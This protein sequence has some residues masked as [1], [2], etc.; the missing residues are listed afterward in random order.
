MYRTIARRTIWS[1][2]MDQFQ[3]P[4]AVDLTLVAHA[5]AVET[6]QIDLVARGWVG[7]F[8]ALL[9]PG[10]NGSPLVWRE[11]GPGGEAE[12]KR[13]Y[14]A[15]FGRFF[16]R[17][18]LRHEHGCRDLRQVHDGREIASGLRIRRRRGVSARGDLPDWV[19][20]NATS[21][22]Y[23]VC[24]AKGSHDQG[25]W[26]VRVPP[27]VNAAMR[28]TNRMEIIDASGVRVQTKNWVVASRWGTQGNARTPTVI[29]MDPLSDGRPLTDAEREKLPRETHA[30][31]LADLLKGLGRAD[32]VGEGGDLSP[33]PS[34]SFA[35]DSVVVAGREGYAAVLVDGSGVFPLRGPQR[36]QRFD[37]LREVSEEVGRKVAVVLLERPAVEAAA[38]REPRPQDFETVVSDN[39][40]TI[41]SDGVTVTWQLDTLEL[42]DAG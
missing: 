38:R 26:E 35:Q 29:T 27:V 2:S 7:L 18:I 14:S 39:G 10:S 1:P 40:Q 30:L 42:E 15:L 36:R 31:F 13:A 17:A 25:D 21:G 23:S 37:A 12:I 8:G 3:T 32:L 20:W 33:S 16:G 5:A 41:T 11:N 22:C 4:H 34:A 28:Q 19:S 24:E 9:Q 6:L